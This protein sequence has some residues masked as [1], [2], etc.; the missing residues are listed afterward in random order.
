MSSKAPGRKASSSSASALT[1]T[2]HEAAQ[3][4]RANATGRPPVVFIHGPW[5]LP[6]SWDRWAKVF[7][8]AGYTASPGAA[9]RQYRSRSTRRRFAVCC[10]YRSRR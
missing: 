4:K 5:L 3:A 9:S 10:R 8:D 6:S 7:E 1:I 2:E